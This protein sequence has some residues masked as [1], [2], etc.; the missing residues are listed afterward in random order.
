MAE[1][2]K[3]KQMIENHYIDLMLY[4]VCVWTEPQNLGGTIDLYSY[5]R[6]SICMSE[7]SA[8]T[9]H[10]FFSDFWY[11]GIFLWLLRLLEPDF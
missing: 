10:L 1:R 4:V 11:Q 3:D 8:R 2:K 6:P 7:D 5:V 9:A